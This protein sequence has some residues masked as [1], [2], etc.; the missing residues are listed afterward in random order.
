MT[1]RQVFTRLN[2]KINL[3]QSVAKGKL[4]VVFFCLTALL[5]Q[6]LLSR[7]A[8]AFSVSEERKVGDKLL[9]MVRTSFTVIDAPDITQYI[10]N[11]GQRILKVT[12]PQY[13]KYHFF[14][15]N[16]KDFNAF[17]APS[18]LIFIHS[19]LLETMDNE[20]E[21]VSVM[22]HEVGHVTSRH[23]SKQVDKSKK[24]GIGTAALLIAGIA[25]GRGALSQALI[26][27]S[28]AASS[29]MH[30][31]FS[32]EDEEE[33]DRLS[34]KWM[35]AMNM[36][37]APMATMLEKMYKISVYQMANIPP[38]LLSHPEPKRRLS[39]IQDMLFS[40]PPHKYTPRDDFP[41]LRIKYRIMAETKDSA[42]LLPIYQRQVKEGK[43]PRKT[44]ANYGLY[45]LYLHGAEYDKAATSLRTVM[46]HFKDEA[47]LH[48]D[49]GM[50]AFRKGEYNE[51]L[52]DFK[53]AL[54]ANPDDAYSAYHLAEALELQGRRAGA[55]KIYQRLLSTIPDFTKLHFRLG[56]LLTDSGK[57]GA[58]HYQ[59]GQYF[60]LN[61]DHKTA[62]YHLNQALKDK[63]SAPQIIKLAN[64]ELA[65]IKEVE[66]E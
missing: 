25:L 60:W 39:Y 61:G 2:K 29:S 21:L 26:T 66:K 62:K 16:N 30:L 12:G 38:F 34:Y 24:T 43:E 48:S 22:A 15:I 3:S 41:F 10:N 56:K 51:A 9:S 17:A 35:V 50:I 13:F 4:L 20:G 44:M 5:I 8:Q 6:P 45:L 14:V 36:D 64:K 1:Y 53:L 58:G 65:K 7:P 63:T 49:L 28:M 55:A 27:G 31:K 23:I 54:A 57:T 32:R 42:S 11:L 52:K 33:A 47:I 40:A 46:S 18:G 37:P 19:G 59:L